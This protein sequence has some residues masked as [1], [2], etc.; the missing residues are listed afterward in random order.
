MVVQLTDDSILVGCGLQL[1][2][3]QLK[4]I[5]VILDLLDGDPH[6]LGLRD[7]SIIQIAVGG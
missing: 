3:D 6:D 2:D 5:M 4:R 1:L 7:G